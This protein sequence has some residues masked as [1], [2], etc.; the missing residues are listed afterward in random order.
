MTSPPQLIGIDLGTSS[1]KVVVVDPSG[2]VTG[3]SSAPYS[4]SR[5]EP[6]YA[7]QDPEAWWQA[8][9][10][11]TRAALEAAAHPDIA[12]IGVTGQ[13]HGTVLLDHEDRSVCPA[14]IWADG[15]SAAEAN[16]FTD[17]IGAQQLIEIAG[18]P[19]APGFQAATLRWLGGHLPD[20]LARTRTVTTPS[21]YIRYK[22]TGQHSVDPSDASGTLL[23]DV[24]DRDWSAPLLRASGINRDMLPAV[25]PS[26]RVA[27]SLTLLGGE[28][29]GIP[30]GTPVAT[31]GADAA[32][33]ALG[34]GVVEAGTLL[35]TFST[36]TQVLLPQLDIATDPL[37]RLHTFCS[38]LEPGAASPG[39]YTMGATLTAGMALTWLSERI[40]SLPPSADTMTMLV[41]EADGVP[42]GS[43][44]LLFLP[45]L[46]GERTPLMDPT[47][48]GAYL[49][50]SAA[51]GRAEM[52]RATIEG[53]AFAA[54]DAHL[55]LQ[56][57]GGQP[58]RIYLA[59][60]GAR[61][62][63]WRQVVADLF[64]LP[65]VSLAGEDHTA[66]GA[67][68]L[69]GAAVGLHDPVAAALSWRTEADTTMPNDG[70]RALYQDLFEVFQR[71]YQALRP[72][73]GY[74]A[75]L[76]AKG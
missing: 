73:M 8:T 50:L 58:E 25:I 34:C 26:S 7:E 24:R 18:S 60:G 29:L 41:A 40:V 22:L 52:V 15:R 74:L 16:A 3:S 59:G 67:A 30:P 23:F 27:G 31:G 53:I 17:E 57:L 36:G 4:T 44:G 14:I 64:G 42:P 6:L 35:L 49:G 72:D 1:V 12:G 32:C 62:Q 20:A 5:P 13:M 21:G 2:V 63:P 47:A 37:G 43:R 76:G 39:W 45:Y 75:E 28:A 19:V 65:V 71:A 61:F 55:A 11:A 70:N 56:S 66:I 46:I 48:R 9:V 68:I 69:A 33:A 10:T 38:V 51:H 54:Y